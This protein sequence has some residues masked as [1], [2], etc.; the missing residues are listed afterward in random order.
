MDARATL[1]LATLDDVGLLLEHDKVLPSATAVIAGGPVAGSW[2]SHPL[3]SPIYNALEALEDAEVVLRLKMVAGKI[4]LVARRLW[5]DVLAVVG[6]KAPW[7]VDGLSDEARIL[8]STVESIPGPLLLDHG[9]RAAGK[10]LEAGLLVHATSV[11]LPTG[12]HVKALQPWSELDVEPAPDPA[13]SRATL[14][15]IV[16]RW[17]SRRR[18]LPWP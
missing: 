14:D 4:T 3:A 15:A 1:L 12:N 17:G 13:S 6:E 16:N 18:L 7:Q 9:T 8:L 10:E 2:W 5:P 11:H